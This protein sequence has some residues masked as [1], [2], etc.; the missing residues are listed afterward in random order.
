[1]GRRMQ[2]HNEASPPKRYDPNDKRSILQVFTASDSIAKVV[3]SFD[4]ES[5]FL[6][7]SSMLRNCRNSAK[8]IYFYKFSVN[9]YKQ[10]REGKSFLCLKAFHIKINEIIL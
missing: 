1:M 2:V 3:T 6:V 4:I 7:L 5:L 9:F 8:K 10:P